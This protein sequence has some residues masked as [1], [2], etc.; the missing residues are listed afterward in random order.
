MEQSKIIKGNR[1]YHALFGWCKVMSPV[2]RD[3][4]LVDLEAY[5]VRYY[6]HGKGCKTITKKNNKPNAILTPIEDLFPDE[7][8]SRE[9]YSK[10]LTFRPEIILSK[11]CNCDNDEC[12]SNLIA[13][14]NCKNCI[15]KI[16]KNG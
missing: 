11:P 4:V 7:N 12:E 15:N 2:I 10:R 14:R 1:L 5:S 16:K 9:M 8:I 3:K 6:Q 13:G